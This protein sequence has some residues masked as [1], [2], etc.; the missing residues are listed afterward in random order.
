MF[1]EYSIHGRHMWVLKMVTQM[2]T[3]HA[4]VC[5]LHVISHSQRS[6]G[7]FDQSSHFQTGN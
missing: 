7:Y 1:P 6:T 5:T 3:Y 4:S 2:Q